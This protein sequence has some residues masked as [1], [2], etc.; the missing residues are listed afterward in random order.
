M[1]PMRPVNPPKNFREKLTANDYLFQIKFDGWYC[2]FANRRAYT[3]TWTDITDWACFNGL[4]LPESALCGELINTSI[5]GSD[6]IQSLRK[7]QTGF[8][9]IAFDAP[10]ENPIEWRLQIAE[11]MAEKYGFRMAES[12]EFPSWDMADIARDDAIS[13]GHEGLVAKRKES[14]WVDG[15][16]KH[17][18][19]FKK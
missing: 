6:G 14:P 16:S 2:V 4:R 9:F 11:Y 12:L 18:Y 7:T 17:W 19:K 1:N 13:R 5:P 3:R 15:N 10:S 8:E